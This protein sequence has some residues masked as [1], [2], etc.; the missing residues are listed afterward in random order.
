MQCRRRFADFEKLHTALVELLQAGNGYNGQ[1]YEE[2]IARLQSVKP[3]KAGHST[4]Q[5][6]VT[7]RLAQL[8]TVLDCISR[9]VAEVGSPL[10]KQAKLLLHKFA[11]AVSSEYYQRN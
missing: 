2:Y 5:T 6:V 10:D 11:F 4:D 3:V 8:Q 7:D 1:L 9:T